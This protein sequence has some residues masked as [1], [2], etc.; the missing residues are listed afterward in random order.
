MAVLGASLDLATKLLALDPD[1]AASYREQVTAARGRKSMRL[2]DFLS[3]VAMLSGVVRHI[4]KSLSSSSN[5]RWSRQPRQRTSAGANPRRRR[6]RERRATTTRRSSAV[7]RSKA[8]ASTRR[9]GR[10]A[11]GK[12]IAE[13]LGEVAKAKGF[14]G[15]MKK[16]HV[17]LEWIGI[18]KGALTQDCDYVEKMG[19]VATPDSC[20]GAANL[21]SM[22]KGLSAELLTS[23]LPCDYYL[24]EIIV[25]ER[26][27]TKYQVIL[28]GKLCVLL[29]S[30]HCIHLTKTLS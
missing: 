9:R 19:W 23:H 12:K 26:E 30:H 29:T 7:S 4:T 3:P 27:K 16:R 20:H 1:K 8:P 6:R 25:P 15:S 17:G 18:D 10:S 5:R 13:A 11:I 28:D 2:T 24:G 21:V 14:E 22:A